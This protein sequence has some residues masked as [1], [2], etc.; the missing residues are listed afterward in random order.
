MP[1]KGMISASSNALFSIKRKCLAWA[2][3]GMTATGAIAGF[4]AIIAIARHQWISSFVWMTVAIAIDSVDG[5]CARACRVKDV[6]PEFDGA[7]L[8]NIVDYFTYVI[9]P[10]S[11]L[12]ETQSM[13][14]GF[15]LLSAVLILLASAYQ[16]CQIDA[17]TEDHCFRG[18]PSYWNVVV[19]Y[20][21]MFGWSEW[22]NFI[23]IVALTAAVFLPVKYLYPSRTP[24]MRPLNIVL[25]GAWGAML[26]LAMFLYPASHKSVLL[27][28]LAYVVYYFIVSL[29][30][31]FASA[32]RQA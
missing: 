32:W 4:L 25:C 19:F 21:F 31:T 20:Q 9:V 16:F 28:S 27:A 3:H 18:F 30:I 11:F 22:L 1:D 5:M 7:L 14:R 12:Y 24:V 10:A 15:N 17:K 2:I 6:L 23:M 8:D 29:Y 26:I 13:P